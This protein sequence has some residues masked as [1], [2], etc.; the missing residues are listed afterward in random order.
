MLLF[1]YTLNATLL[2]LHEIESGYEKEWEILHLP[3]KLTGFLLLHI[4]LV[5]LI[6]YGFYALIAYPHAQQIVAIAAGASGFVPF[7]VHKILVRKKEHFN[8]AISNV[9][10]F[11]NVV[12]GAILIM[13]GIVG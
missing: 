7:L 3:G 11:A 13:W 1:L 6:F 10:I 12:S 4:P 8:K 5:F 2:I 9:L